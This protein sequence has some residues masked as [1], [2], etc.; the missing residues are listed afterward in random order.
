MANKRNF[1]IVDTE[2]TGLDPTQGH[3]I[4]QLSAKAINAWDLTEHHAGTFNAYIKPQNP[5]LASPEAIEKIG[6]VWTKA[7]QEGLQPKVV[8]EEFVKWVESVNDNNNWYSRPTLVAHNM[9][10]DMK[11]IEYWFQHYK[12]LTLNDKGE[13]DIPWSRITLDTV[14]IL[15][16]IFESDASVS[17]MKLDTFLEKMGLTRK[18]DTHDALED[19]E[20]LSQIFVRSLKFLRE[21]RK[22]MRVKT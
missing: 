5:E 3:E 10:F 8:F 2:T 12:V 20:L 16:S 4:V 18:S 7:T 1:I 17:D 22:R 9:S 19:V 15:F 21:C 14:N 6:D 13:L 11:F